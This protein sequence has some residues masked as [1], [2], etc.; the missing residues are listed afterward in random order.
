MEN[1]STEFPV[2][3][4]G[5][6]TQDLFLKP[7]DSLVHTI[8]EKSLLC[9]PHGGKTTTAYMEHHGGGGA[10]NVSVSLRRLGLSPIVLGAVGDDSQGEWIINLLQ[11]EGVNTD[12]IQEKKGVK[13]GFSVILNAQDGERTVIFSSEANHQFTDFDELVFRTALIRG[14]YLCHLSSVSLEN[15]TKKIEQ[16]LV[17]NPLLP[18]AWNPG[19]E[20]I[21]LPKEESKTL[22]ARCNLLFLNAEEASLWNQVSGSIGDQSLKSLASPFLEM[23]VQEVIIT[24]GKNGAWAFGKT[25]EDL[26]FP[27]S[28]LSKVDTLGA[29][30]AFGSTFFG[31]WIL[32][33]SIA[34]CGEYAS[35]NAGSVVAYRGAQDGLLPFS[36]VFKENSP[37][38]H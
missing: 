16:F 24:D 1:N 6:L 32:G 28:N 11:K 12:F 29:G 9:L 17:Q 7:E 33:K 19:K 14:L 20:R 15:I 36:K 37:T 31:S 38:G 23:G 18:F 3:V 5:S 35:R 30:D 26:F 4:L 8:S 10:G 34:E 2:V 13:S 21:S 27:C 25:H 22:L